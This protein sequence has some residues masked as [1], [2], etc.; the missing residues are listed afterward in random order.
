MSVITQ[1]LV[2]ATSAQFDPVRRS[3]QSSAAVGV[4]AAAAVTVTGGCDM[5]CSVERAHEEEDS[6][7]CS[8][9]VEGFF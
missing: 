5:S 2:A 4:A 9:E 1:S 8:V 6:L 7:R 3:S